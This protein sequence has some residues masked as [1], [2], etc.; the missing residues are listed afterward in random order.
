MPASGVSRELVVVGKDSS[1]KLND[2]LVGDVWLAGGQSNMG[3]PLFSA[4]NAKEVLP[5]AQD[6][7]LRFFSVTKQDRRRTA[8]RLHPANGN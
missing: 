7:Q 2:V 8:D 5:K 6:A 4:H 1:V 3:F